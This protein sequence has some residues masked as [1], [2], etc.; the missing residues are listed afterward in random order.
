MNTPTP[1]EK[2]MA[3]KLDQVPVPDMA[4]SIWARI[5]LQLDAVVDNPDEHTPE[6]KKEHTPAKKSMI[7]HIGK[8]WYGIAGV[9]VAATT[10]WWYTSRPTTVPE[11]TPPVKNIP[12]TQAPVDSGTIKPPLEKKEVPVLPKNDTAHLLVPPPPVTDS[13]AAPVL[14]PPTADSLFVPHY[15]YAPPV[16]DTV[17]PVK[18]PRGVPGITEDDY[19]ISVQKDSAV[20]NN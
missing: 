6:A 20:K 19:R 11:K 10:M 7:K 2:L 14:L 12:A 15:R 9:A 16:K 4:D 17:H 3:A 1:Y 18:K 8:G 13:P 5:E